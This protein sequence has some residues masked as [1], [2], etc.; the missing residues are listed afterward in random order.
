[1]SRKLIAILRGLSPPEAEAI[2]AALVGAGITRLEVPMNSPEPLESIK[3]LA[4]KFG[5][6][7]LVGAG[8][9]LS[10]AEVDAVIGAGGQ[11]IVAPNTDP[12]VISRAKMVRVETIPGC[13]T[14]TECLAALKAGADALKLFP[15]SLLG[16]SGMQ[17]LKAVLPADV[18]LYPVGGVDAPDFAT[19]LAAGAAGFGIGGALYQPGMSPEE[20]GARAERIV[21]AYDR[22]RRMEAA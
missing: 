13:F 2:G 8:T 4:Q 15:A 6:Q 5:S 22:A 3:L 10:A 1:M 16:P 21:V 12:N 18:Q 11:M 7:A 9:V 17:A 14:A 20:V 19:W